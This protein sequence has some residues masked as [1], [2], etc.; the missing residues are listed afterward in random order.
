M[1]D[2]NWENHKGNNVFFGVREH[3]M[4]AILNG[5]ALH[6]GLRVYGSTF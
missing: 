5:M 3:G 2:F 6:G 4:A 1:G